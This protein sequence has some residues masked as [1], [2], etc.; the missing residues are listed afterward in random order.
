MWKSTIK[1]IVVEI[2]KFLSVLD[3]T[4]IKTQAMRIVKDYLPIFSYSLQH[5]IFHLKPCK[6]FHIWFLQEQK[7]EISMSFIIIVYKCK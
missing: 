1:S 7:L 4:L 2:L 6:N 5:K 3:R